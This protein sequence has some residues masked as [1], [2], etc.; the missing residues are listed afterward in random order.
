MNDNWKTRKLGDV[1]SL[2]YGKPLPKD[3]RCSDKGYPAYGANGVKTYAVKPYWNKPSIIVGRKG[4][5]GAVNLVEGG[6]WPLDV[7]YYVTFDSSEYDLKFLFYTLTSLNLPS[8]ATGVKPGI[9]RNIV[10]AIEQKFPALAEQKRIVAILDEAFEGIDTA[11]ANTAKNLKNSRELFKSYLNRLFYEAAYSDPIQSL[12]CISQLIVD[13][14]HK[15]APTQETGYPSIRTPNIG[16]GYL[17]LDNVKRVS[18]ETYHHWTKRALPKGGDLIL[19]RE[20]PAGN[21]GVIPEGEQVCLGQRTV[22]IR[23][24]YNFVNSKY[25]AYLMLHPLMQK[26]LLSTSTGATVQHVNMRDI[27]ALGI[28]RLPSI[29]EQIK[30]IDALERV[31]EHVAQLESIYQQK[32]IAL[33]ELKQSLLQKAFSGELTANNVVEITAQKQS[34]KHIEATSPEFAAHIMAAAYHWHASQSREKTFGR[35]KA[36]K[37][38]HLIESLANIDLGRQPIKDAA[39]PNDFQHMQRAEEWARDRGF[40]EF[41]KRP[42][43]QRG[44]DFRKGARYGDLVAE[45]MQTLAPYENVLKRV[46]KVL[47]PLNTAETEILAT[48]YAAW[49]N[50]LLEGVEPAENAIIHEARENWH[51]D[52]LK[53]SEEQFRNAISQLR[54]NGLVPQGRGKRVTGQESLAL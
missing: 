13:C 26:R 3:Q 15:T 35:V 54:H 25:L 24:K 7:T 10:Y 16:E 42:T 9:N 48:V 8:F 41:V 46:I 32:L 31:Q 47:M 29:D 45:A 44:Y 18:E 17:F 27:R 43:G 53:Y 21:V 33:K 49:N 37:T 4:T 40:F 2:E 50:L 1:I 11:I 51:A 52:K 38:L 20:A 34:N 14:E 30:D 6:F 39:G 12:S 23:P 28:G 22:L 19:A 36:Q 5:A